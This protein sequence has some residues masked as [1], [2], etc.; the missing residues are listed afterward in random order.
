MVRVRWPVMRW[1]DLVAPSL[2]RNMAAIVR[3]TSGAI[4]VMGG[5]THSEELQ[6]LSSAEIWDGAIWSNG[7]KMSNGLS[8][9]QSANK[10]KNL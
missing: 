10:S 1:G 8:S 2:E 9:L 4:V 5:L 7:P 6:A 3:D